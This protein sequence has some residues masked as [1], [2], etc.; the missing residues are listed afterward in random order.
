MIK[1]ESVYGDEKNVS[2]EKFVFR[3]SVYAGIIHDGKILM[4]KNRSND[5]FWLPGGGIEICE[6]A[7]EALKREVKEETG[8][9][10]E[11]EEFIAFREN[12]FYYDPSD[13]AYHAFLFFYK[14]RPLSF[15][16][17]END[18][19]N[20]GEAHSPEWIGLEDIKTGKF[21]EKINKKLLEV[22]KNEL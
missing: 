5:K 22:L 11:I 15:D 18:K 14:C 12:L 20:D 7:G 9:D 1:C 4:I 10:I 19:I 13:E 21:D 3:P 16:L 8:I 2:K 17:L 6:S